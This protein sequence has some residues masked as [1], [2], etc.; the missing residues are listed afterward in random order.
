MKLKTFLQILILIIL[1]GAIFYVVY[2]KFDFFYKSDDGYKAL[3]NYY[4]VNKVT[5]KVQFAPAAATKWSNIG[6]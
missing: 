5:G 2:P 3:T 1:V 6:N 4:R